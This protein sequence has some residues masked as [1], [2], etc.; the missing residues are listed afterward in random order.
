MLILASGK[1][2]TG[3]A[4]DNLVLVSEAKV[5]NVD[6]YLA[7]SV[8]VGLSLNALAGWW[9]ADPLSA[10]LLVYYGVREGRHLWAEAH[11]T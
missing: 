8:L 9:W 1:R 7:G 10:M 6:A 11:T 5:T 4:L 2:R 3:Q